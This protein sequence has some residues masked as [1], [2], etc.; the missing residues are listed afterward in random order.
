MLSVPSGARDGIVFIVF[1]AVTGVSV[2]VPSSAIATYVTSKLSVT[3]IF[4]NVTFP[5]F[6][7]VIVYV[8]LSP[9]FTFVS[10]VISVPFTFVAVF[11]T[12][13]PFVLSVGTV[14]SLPSSCVPSSA[15]PI[16]VLTIFANVSTSVCVTV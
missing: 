13:I 12:S 9:A 16:A 7:T 8:T 11:V 1:P 14:L 6:F 2:F 15:L 4:F 10:S 5:V 3:A